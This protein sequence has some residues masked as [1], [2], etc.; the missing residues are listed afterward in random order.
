MTDF[1]TLRQHQLLSRLLGLARAQAD[2]LAAEE[3]DRFLALMD[4]RETVVA[5][6]I[7]LEEAPPPANVLPFPTIVPRPNDPDARA[8]LGG[9]LRSILRQDEENEQALRAQM[10]EVHGSLMRVNQGAA[11]GRGYAAAAGS[12]RTRTGLDKAC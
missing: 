2:A 3:L 12:V 1:A 5:D 10:D 9:L 6:L 7:A 11:A 4:E 8:A